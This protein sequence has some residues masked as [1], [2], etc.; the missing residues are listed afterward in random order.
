M[1]VNSDFSSGEKFFSGSFLPLKWGVRTPDI[2]KIGR[3]KIRAFDKIN[4]GKHFM[5]L[6]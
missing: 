5:S 4:K 2:L 6:S 3:M 1:A